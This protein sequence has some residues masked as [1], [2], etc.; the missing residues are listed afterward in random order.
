ME[1]TLFLIRHCLLIS[2]RGLH[3]LIAG[4]TAESFLAMVDTHRSVIRSA[5]VDPELLGMRE[6]VISFIKGNTMT[7]TPAFCHTED[8]V[9]MGVYH[10]A[11][12]MH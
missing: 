10:P 12:K 8:Y 1:T 9:H 5:N 6:R 11:F 2:G 4:R 3:S 7:G